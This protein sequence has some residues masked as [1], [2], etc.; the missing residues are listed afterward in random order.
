MNCSSF[1]TDS[2]N[3]PSAA[4]NVSYG[5]IEGWRFPIRAGVS[6]VANALDA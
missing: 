2:T 5:A 6:P 3:S 1:P 4:A